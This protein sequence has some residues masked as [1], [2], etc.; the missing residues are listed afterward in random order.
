MKHHPPTSP[1]LAYVGDLT[2]TNTKGLTMG[3]PYT[4][5]AFSTARSTGN[6]SLT[7]WFSF[8]F[9]TVE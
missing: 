7:S 9:Q 5:K 8:D 4:V 1:E 2:L 6:L 3:P